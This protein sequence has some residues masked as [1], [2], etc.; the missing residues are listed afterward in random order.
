M[1]KKENKLNPKSAEDE[2]NILTEIN[3]RGKKTFIFSYEFCEIKTPMGHSH[4]ILEIH[5]TVGHDGTCW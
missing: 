3:Y 2:S 4:S 5:S 1:H